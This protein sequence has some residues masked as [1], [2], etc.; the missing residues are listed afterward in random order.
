MRKPF[1]VILDTQKFLPL[2][3]ALYIYFSFREDE[4]NLKGGYWKMRCP[5][6]KTVSLPNMQICEEKKTHIRQ[7]LTTINKMKDR[8]M[9]GFFHIILT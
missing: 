6:P 8:S 7:I 1:C 3:E 9:T 5:K 4:S 2:K